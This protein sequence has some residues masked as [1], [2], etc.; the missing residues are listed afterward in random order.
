MCVCEVKDAPQVVLLSL[1]QMV[2]L[3]LLPFDPCVG[4][5]HNLTLLAVIL[6]LTSCGLDPCLDHFSSLGEVCPLGSLP[7]LA[8]ESAKQCSLGS[9][10]IQLL[11]GPSWLP[12]TPGA[13]CFPLPLPPRPLSGHDLVI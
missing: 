3:S 12:V 9:Q 7:W 2:L 11:L 5:S 13:L 4:Q 8:G 6:S 10:Q 1:L